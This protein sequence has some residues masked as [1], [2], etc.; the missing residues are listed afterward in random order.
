VDDY[1]LDELIEKPKIQSVPKYAYDETADE[2]RLEFDIKEYSLKLQAYAKEKNRIIHD[3]EYRK[4]LLLRKKQLESI[5]DDA[6]IQAN[7]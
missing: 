7:N 4:E 2:T 5:K 3:E 1:V 6:L